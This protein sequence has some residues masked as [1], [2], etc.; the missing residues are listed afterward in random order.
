VQLSSK[1]LAE[2]QIFTP[3]LKLRPK[4]SALMTVLIVNDM[5]AAQ[6]GQGA[7]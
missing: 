5:A 1:I 4:H 6:L 2:R 3:D 7:Q